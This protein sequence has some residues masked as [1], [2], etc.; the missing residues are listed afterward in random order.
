MNENRNRIP[1]AQNHHPSPI[2]KASGNGGRQQGMVHKKPVPQEHGCKYKETATSA[3]HKRAMGEKQPQGQTTSPSGPTSTEILN[4]R[5]KARGM[6][7]TLGKLQNSKSLPNVDLPHSRPVVVQPAPRNYR[8]LQLQAIPTRGQVSR[9]CL[10]K[11][12]SR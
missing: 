3:A 6:V 2:A 1:V 5:R 10:L 8:G 9:I 7:E 11:S 4:G 12:P